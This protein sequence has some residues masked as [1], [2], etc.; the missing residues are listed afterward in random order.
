MNRRDYFSDLV[1]EL[2][3]WQALVSYRYDTKD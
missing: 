1:A 2:R 3:K